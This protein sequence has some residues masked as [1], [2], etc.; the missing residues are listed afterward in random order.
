MNTGCT[1]DTSC[2]IESV[3]STAPCR[4]LFFFAISSFLPSHTPSFVVMTHMYHG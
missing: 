1:H 4:Q 3:S 2:S